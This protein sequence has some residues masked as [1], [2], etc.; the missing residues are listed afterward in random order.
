MPRACSQGRHEAA[1]AQVQ[2][3]GK[4]PRGVVKPVEQPLGRLVQHRGDTL[5]GGRRAVAMEA[6]GAAVEHVHLFVGALIAALYAS[7]AGSSSAWRD[8]PLF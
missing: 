5:D 4:T 1:S 8:F 7:L 2:R 6:D 3:A